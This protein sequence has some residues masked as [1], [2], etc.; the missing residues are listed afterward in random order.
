MQE[1]LEVN[2][3]LIFF[4]WLFFLLIIS[5]FSDDQYEKEN[6]VIFIHEKT[7]AI[8]G[9]DVVITD[10]TEFRIACETKYLYTVLFCGS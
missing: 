8:L 5:G 3:D 2:N 10:T 1:K 9:C 6:K 4:H 7:G